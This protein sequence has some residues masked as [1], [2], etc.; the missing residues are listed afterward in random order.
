MM[1]LQCIFQQLGG[2]FLREPQAMFFSREPIVQ[3]ATAKRC[4]FIYLPLL[5]SVKR[6]FYQFFNYQQ[7]LN[8]NKNKTRRYVRRKETAVSVAFKIFVSFRSVYLFQN[9]FDFVFS[10]LPKPSFGLVFIV[11]GCCL[12]VFFENVHSANSNLIY[13]FRDLI[14]LFNEIIM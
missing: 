1:Y 13:F 3:R 4:F 2:L 9:R 8:F 7:Q 6:F 14:F 12:Q 11:I 5:A 10:K